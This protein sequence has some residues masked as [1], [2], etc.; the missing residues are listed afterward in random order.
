MLVLAIVVDHS[1]IMF[2]YPSRTFDEHLTLTA[3]LLLTKELRYRKL[4]VNMAARLMFGARD[5]VWP[6]TNVVTRAT[7]AHV[8]MIT[9]TGVYKTRKKRNCQTHNRRHLNTVIY[10]VI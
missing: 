6:V 7:C 10:R 3:L 1:S 5:L 9:P 8:S 2:I 4:S